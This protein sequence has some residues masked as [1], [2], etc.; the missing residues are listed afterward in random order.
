MHKSKAFLMQIG[1]VIVLVISLC[2]LAYNIWLD[3]SKIKKRAANLS[4]MEAARNADTSN[5]DSL[6]RF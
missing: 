3:E 6:L 1:G 5:F 2:G 4:P